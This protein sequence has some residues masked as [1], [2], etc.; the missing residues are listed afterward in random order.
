MDL[1]FILGQSLQAN[2]TSCSC[3]IG[4][5]AL[6]DNAKLDKFSELVVGDEHFVLVQAL[7]WARL[8]GAL[9][10]LIMNCQLLNITFGSRMGHFVTI[11]RMRDSNPGN[12][13]LQ[14]SAACSFLISSHQDSNKLFCQWRNSSPCKRSLHMLQNL[15]RKY[16]F[17]DC[18]A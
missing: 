17:A 5:H 1:I 9:T 14:S 7:M 11:Q 3:R 12:P 8:A 4:F 13:S 2:L 10:I 15:L 6:V 18:S 16:I